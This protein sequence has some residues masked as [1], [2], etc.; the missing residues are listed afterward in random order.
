V[1][2]YDSLGN[3][4]TESQGRNHHVRY[5]HNNRNQ[6]VQ[7]RENGVFYQYTYDRR[8]NLTE[9]T[10]SRHCG[11]DSQ[12]NRQYEVVATFVF[13]SANR[14]VRG[15]N[16]RG[17][18]SHYIF[19]GLGHLVAQEL[20]IERGTHGFGDVYTETSPQLTELSHSQDMRVR[21]LELLS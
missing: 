21:G 17:E 10:R 16:E 2:E 8:G 6:L 15:A 1:Y 12:P 3:L 13:D 19:N 9:V 14:M 4:V 18:Q 20:I 7:R 5:W 11:L